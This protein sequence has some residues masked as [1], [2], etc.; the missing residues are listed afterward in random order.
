M[1]DNKAHA[2]LYPKYH[3]KYPLIRF[4]H[5]FSKLFLKIMGVTLFEGGPIEKPAGAVRLLSGYSCSYLIPVSEAAKEFILVD[6]GMDPHAEQI[7]GE[8]YRHD[9]D[10]RAV[11]AIFITHGH[12]DHVAGVRRFPDADVYIGEADRDFLLGTAAPQDLMGKL[13]GKQ[14]KLAVKNPDKLHAVTDNQTITIGTR[15]VRSFAMPG[16]TKGSMAYCID[17]ALF[18]GDAITFDKSGKIQS[19]PPPVSNDLKI[20]AQSVKRLLERIESENIAITTLIP[21]HSGPGTMR[22]LREYVNT[23]K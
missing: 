13:M 19:P 21:N 23:L 1:S 12:S 5:G 6:A 8:L 15:T 9:V 3:P 16:H 4:H 10:E 7:L 2:N 14:P 22:Q 18:V 11:K 17:D 20:A